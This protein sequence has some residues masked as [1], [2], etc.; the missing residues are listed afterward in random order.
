M[1]RVT[2]IDESEKFIVRGDAI[3]MEQ[4]V[5]VSVIFGQSP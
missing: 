2:R 4:E 5:F 3:I 1:P